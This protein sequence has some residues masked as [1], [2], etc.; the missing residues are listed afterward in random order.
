MKN[1]SDNEFFPDE[2]ELVIVP[3]E[4][5][6]DLHPFAPRDVKSV[7]EEYLFQCSAKGLKEIRII[8]GRGTGT[9][10]AI[11]R[12]ALENNPL[13]RNFEDAPPEAGGWGATRVWLV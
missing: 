13:V 9:Q 1:N 11:V 4:S 6:I 5:S 3:I 12:Q 7:V 8:H 10:R 2:D